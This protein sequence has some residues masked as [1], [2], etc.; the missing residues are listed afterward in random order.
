MP[1]SMIGSPSAYGFEKPRARVVLN[2]GRMWRS[3]DWPIGPSTA[4]LRASASVS[5]TR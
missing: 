2:A 3:Q 5:A 4:S 1:G